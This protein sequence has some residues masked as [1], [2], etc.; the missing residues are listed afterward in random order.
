MYS[1]LLRNCKGGGSRSG[2]PFRENSELSVKVSADPRPEQLG[3]WGD[4]VVKSVSAFS[5]WKEKTER[6]GL[7]WS[8]EERGTSSLLAM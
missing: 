8:L 5:V 3:M 2:Y 1:P 7:E 6:I 4:G